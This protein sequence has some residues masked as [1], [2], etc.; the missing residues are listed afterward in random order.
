MALGDRRDHALQNAADKN[1][2]STRE[3]VADH[4]RRLLDDPRRE[5]TRILRFFREYFEYAKAVDIFKDK[6]KG[7]VHA[8]QVLVA[9][10]DRLIL[11]ILQEDRDVLRRLL[12]TDLT[13]ANYSENKNRRNEGPKPAVKVNPN[14]NKGQKVPEYVYGLDAGPRNSPRRFPRAGASAS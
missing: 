1:A 10:T 7:F 5:P 8:P 14:N 6:P 9:D 12:T 13:F 11:H 3:K 4:V 2:L